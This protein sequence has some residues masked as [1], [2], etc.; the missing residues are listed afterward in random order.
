M[1][2]ACAIVVAGA[3]G[4]K[5]HVPLGGRQLTYVGSSKLSFLARITKLGIMVH[6]D[7]VIKTPCEDV[8]DAHCICKAQ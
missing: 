6:L 3:E 5:V 1:L 8:A 7:K 4:Y 2:W